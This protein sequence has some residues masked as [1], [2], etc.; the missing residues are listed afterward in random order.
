MHPQ[1]PVLVTA[2]ILEKEGKILLAQRP[3]TDRLAGLWEFPGGKIEPHETPQDCL[4][5]EIEEELG[6]KVAV[7]ELLAQTD[8]RYEHI[9]IRLLAYRVIYLSGQFCLH[10]HAAICWVFPPQ[11]LQYPLA[12]ADIPIAEKLISLGR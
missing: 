2:A 12:P 6:I 4:A 1:Q 3:A 10:H 7:G 9:Y 8:Y 11:L 5:R